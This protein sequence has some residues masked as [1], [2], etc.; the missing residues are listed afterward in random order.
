MRYREFETSI[1]TVS[2]GNMTRESCRKEHLNLTAKHGPASRIMAGVMHARIK[3]SSDS[4]KRA[5]L[6]PAIPDMNKS[7]QRH[8][9][10]GLIRTGS[11]SETLV[12]DRPY[13]DDDPYARRNEPVVRKESNHVPVQHK[14]PSHIGWF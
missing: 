11:Q 10:R 1:S 5:Y 9:L 3:E 2:L 8:Q 14:I 13:R 7:F 4:P 12:D 6:S